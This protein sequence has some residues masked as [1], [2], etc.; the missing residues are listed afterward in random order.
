[1]KQIYVLAEKN[2][3][4]YEFKKHLWSNKTTTIT[5]WL[6]HHPM[7]IYAEN[8]NEA[9]NKYVLHSSYGIDDVIDYSGT[10]AWDIV[11][12]G[13][14]KLKKIEVVDAKIQHSI[15]WLSTHMSAQDFKEWWYNND[16]E[17]Y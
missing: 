14:C 16:Q 11:T 1:M 10:N 5:V 12:S 13:Q 6:T 9:H 2:T 3:Y 15:K 17:N 8:F 7:A 4:E